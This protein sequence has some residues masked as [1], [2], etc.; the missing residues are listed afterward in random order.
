MGKCMILHQILVLISHFPSSLSFYE[1]DIAMGF[2]FLKKLFQVSE[3]TN[4][5][6][7]LD[8]H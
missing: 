2:F 1:E 7:K 8:M 3:G 4:V 6:C 5:G